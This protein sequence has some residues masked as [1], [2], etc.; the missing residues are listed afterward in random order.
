[1]LS[2]QLKIIKVVFYMRSVDSLDTWIDNVTLIK[3]AT[4]PPIAMHAYVGM[5]DIFCL[6][7]GVIII[8]WIIPTMTH[9]HK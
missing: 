6:I 5:C 2:T 8:L 1:M 4:T 9:D 7:N 3:Y